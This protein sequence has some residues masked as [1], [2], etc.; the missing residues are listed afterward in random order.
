[1]RTPRSFSGAL[2]STLVSS[3]IL[4]PTVSAFYLP[5]VAPRSYKADEP[6]PLHV[7]RLTPFRSELDPQLHSTVAYDY[8]YPAF[9]F[10]AP[11]HGPQDVGHESLGAVMFGDRIKDSPFELLMRKNETCKRLC[12]SVKFNKRSA[13]FVNERIRQSYALNWLVDGLPAGQQYRLADSDTIY[14]SRGFPLGDIPAPDAPPALNNHYDIVVDYHETSPG[15]Y[16]VVGVLVQPSSRRDSRNV[17]EKS[18]LCGDSNAPVYLNEEGSA[19]E[20]TWTYSVYWRPS[21][22]AWAVRWDSYLHVEDPKIH[23]FS[24]VNSA[25][26]VVF[27]VGTV[28][29]I[30]M[31]ALKRDFARYNRLNTFSLDDFSA[32]GPDAIE[33]VQEDSGW[34]LVHGDVFRSPPSPLLLSVFLGNGAQL[35]LMTALTIA[36]AL[37]GFLSPSNRG[38]LGTAVLILYAILGAVGGYVAARTYKTFGGEAW[39]QNII[40]TPLFVPGLVFGTFFLLNLFLWGRGSSGAVPFTTMLALVGIW[41]LIS[42]PLS[43]LGSWLGFKAAAFASPVRTNQI[44][45]QIPPATSYLRPVPSMLLV[46]ALPFG[47]IFVEL[48]FILNSLWFGRIYYMFG[49]LFLCF[50]IMVVTCAAVTIMF[51]YYLLCAENY[52]WQWRAFNSAGAGAIFVFLFAIVYWMWKM[53]FAGLT[54]MVLFVGYSALISVLFY[55]LTGKSRNLGFPPRKTFANRRAKGLLVSS[56]AGPLCTESTSRF[57]LTEVVG[58]NS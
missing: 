14:Y 15:E 16:R 9:H 5:G 57:G 49:F 30:L 53:R 52:R 46:G 17:D 31:R 42:V 36:F 18:A 45:R 44:P 4:L 8:Y 54:S 23:W 7:N 40:L 56:P 29:A 1:M 2:I 33:D 34:K 11:A 41:F 3:L 32:T 38:S 28:S 58:F 22:V 37:L 51:V 21:R 6:V 27:L 10:C 13:G 55:I 20:V 50:G 19:V 39:K 47:A 35:F 12:N 43:V 25:F 48:F 24:L 26:I